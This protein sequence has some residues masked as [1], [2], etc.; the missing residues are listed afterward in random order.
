M[1]ETTALWL[2]GIVGAWLV[3]VTSAVFKLWVGMS[4]IETAFVLISKRA[5]DILHRDD[6][7]YGIDGLLEKYIARSH[8]L[9]YDEWIELLTKCELISKDVTI[10]KDERL[11]AGLLKD[12]ASFVKELAIHKTMIKPHNYEV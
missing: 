8:E 12:L 10:P 1:S 9:S 6:D 7:K 5:A 11:V 4:R 3:I 2:F